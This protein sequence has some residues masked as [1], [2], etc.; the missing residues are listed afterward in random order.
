MPC[1]LVALLSLFGLW[2][3]QCSSVVYVTLSRILLDFGAVRRFWKT[4]A[5]ALL[6]EASH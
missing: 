5:R 2:G 6:V 4:I 1:M 3:K